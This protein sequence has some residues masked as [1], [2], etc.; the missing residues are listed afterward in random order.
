MGIL[1]PETGK[2]VRKGSCLNT[3]AGICRSNARKC[4]PSNQASVCDVF[5]TEALSV[6][7][8]PNRNAPISRRFYPLVPLQALMHSTMPRFRPL[9]NAKPRTCAIAG[10]IG[11]SRSGRERWGRTRCSFWSR[12]IRGNNFPLP[13]DGLNISDCPERMTLPVSTVKRPIRSRILWV[14]KNLTMRYN[15]L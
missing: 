11:N 12:I 6:I 2:A 3:D 9:R 15:K 13:R 8:R 5:V 7:W 4:L 14:F 10:R 1:T